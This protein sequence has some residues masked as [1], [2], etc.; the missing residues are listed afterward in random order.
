MLV[1]FTLCLPNR[2]NENCTATQFCNLAASGARESCLC[3][4]ATGRDACVQLGVCQ[5]TPCSLCQTCLTGM[6]DGQ[7]LSASYTYNFLTK[8]GDILGV[9]NTL[10]SAIPTQYFLGRSPLSWDL[11]CKGLND[12]WT[13]SS[14]LTLPP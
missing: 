1:L 6:R 8:C 4:E 2:F 10:C 13:L 9:G 5:T 11:S 14:L 12:R 3:D 7:N